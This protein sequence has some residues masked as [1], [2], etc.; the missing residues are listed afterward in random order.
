M[1]GSIKGLPAQVD[2]PV[3]IY[4]KTWGRLLGFDSPPSTPEQFKE[5]LCSAA[6]YNNDLPDRKMRGTGGWLE[7]ASHLVNTGWLS[8][9]GSESPFSSESNS[10][11]ESDQIKSTLQYV[12]DL[13]GSGCSWQ[14]KNPTPYEYFTDRMAFMISLPADK[15]QAFDISYKAA[16]GKDEW[17]VISV[18]QKNEE[19]AWVPQIN[20]F[21][22]IRSENNAE[23]LAAWLVIRWLTSLETEKKL[24]L[25]DGSLPATSTN[26]QVVQSAGTLPGQL[27]AWMN[28][29]GDAISPPYLPDWVF[30]REIL[31]D[32]FYQTY[33]S[34][35]TAED[36]P[37]ILKTM[38]EMLA[39]LQENNQP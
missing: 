13:S 23:N 26:W 19:P 32:G 14:G 15:V 31:Q 5:Q 38:T 30:A 6:R 24:S 3:F 22:A 37:G 8:S 17:V 29:A 2:T 34:T 20:Y 4:N 18:P 7:D 28:S 10:S 35:T 25:S 11:L 33:L 1:E 39:D 12:K 9:F 21:T 36:I 27:S 16:K